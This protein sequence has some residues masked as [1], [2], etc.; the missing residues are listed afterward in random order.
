MRH[1]GI[2]TDGHLEKSPMTDLERDI[3]EER[4]AIREYD[5]GQSRADAEREA[6]VEARAYVERLKDEG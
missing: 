2:Q 3:Y 4:A 6:R 5:G 1:M